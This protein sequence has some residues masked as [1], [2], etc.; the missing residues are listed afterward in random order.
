VRQFFP[1]FVAIFMAAGAFGGARPWP[2]TRPASDA[3]VSTSESAALFVGIREFPYDRTLTEVRYAVDDAI[4][5]AHLVAI[6]RQPRLVQPNRVVLAL[7]GK[8]QKPESHAQL[9]ALRAAGASIQPAREADVLKL[10]E[11]QARAVGRN[12]VLIAS[13]ATH[14]INDDGTQWL[15]TSDSLVRHRGAGVSE[16][17]VREIVSDAGVPRALILIDACRQRLRADTRAGDADAR[18]AA[19]LMKALGAINGQV[20]ISAAAAGRYAYDDD[21]RRNGVFTAAVMDG[22]RCLAPADE[23]GY[24]TVDTLSSFV[25]S[26]VLTWIQR[27]RDPKARVATQLY[28]EGACKRMPLSVCA[29]G[30]VPAGPPP[31]P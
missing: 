18:S 11:E 13:F 6:E 12:G 16:A 1:V 4:G 8:P 17:K 24:V 27:N 5:L 23:R 9:Q 20:V 30:T 28:C 19:A 3:P 31:A 14:G 7:S 21:V 10:L 15:L 22:L 29:S 25:E 26:E 2:K